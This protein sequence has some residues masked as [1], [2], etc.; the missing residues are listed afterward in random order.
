MSQVTVPGT[1]SVGAV[2]GRPA[3]R[4]AGEA[5][6]QNWPRLAAYLAQSG[7]T[8]VTGFAPG[9]RNID[10]VSMRTSMRPV[11]ARDGSGALHDR[12]AN[13]RRRR[14]SVQHAVSRSPARLPRGD[15]DSRAPGQ[16]DV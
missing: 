5:V 10:S 14:P 6:R 13:R 9:S 11:A 16:N 4:A 15:A 8:L 12:D 1:L 2:G 7:M 3:L